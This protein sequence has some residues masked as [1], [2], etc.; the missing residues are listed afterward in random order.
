VRCV[1]FSPDAKRVA[2]GGGV[3]DRDDAPRDPVR[4]VEK[5]SGGEV[6]LWDA[7]TG[8][9]LRAV[10]AYRDYVTGIAFSPDGKRLAAGST[11][12]SVRVWDPE[13]GDELLALDGPHGEVNGIAYAPDGKQIAAAV[14]DPC[15]PDKPGEVVIWDAQTGKVER[16]LRGHER[17]VN[18]VAYSGDGR[19]LVSGGGCGGMG[20][21]G[22]YAGG[23]YGIA[24]AATPTY[25][26]YGGGP[27]SYGMHGCY[28]G[29]PGGVGEVKV[30]DPRTG[31][32]LLSLAGASSQVEK[33]VAETRTR[34]VAYTVLKTVQK[35]RNVVIDG[36]TVPQTYTEQVPTTEYRQVCEVIKKKVIVSAS[37]CVAS[38]AFSGDNQR[39]VCGDANGGVQVYEAHLC[40]PHANLRMYAG[41]L[42]CVAYS[43]DGRRL[44]TGGESGDTC[45]TCQ[46]GEVKVWDAITGEE[47]LSLRG[48]S[49]FIYGLAFSPDGTR[50]AVATGCVDQQKKPLPGEVKVWDLGEP[51]GVSP[52]REPLTLKGHAG[53]V[54]GVAWSPDGSRLVS[55]GTDRTVKLWS[56]ADGKVIQTIKGIPAEVNAVAYGPEGKWVAAA[57]GDRVNRDVPGEVRLFDAQTGDPIRTLKGLP[58]PAWCLALSADGKRIAAGSGVWDEKKREFTRGEVKVW[59]AATGNE[60]LTIQGHAAEVNG[61]GFGGDGKWVATAGGDWVVRV[62][63]AEN[64]NEVLALK[65]HAGVVTAVAC[66]PDGVHVASAGADSLVKVWDVVRARESVPHC[67]AA[68]PALGPASLRTEFD[69]WHLAFGPDG[70]RL[71]AGGIRYGGGVPT[72]VTPDEGGKPA[73]SRETGW[74][75][76]WDAARR[77]VIFTA[78][79]HDSPVIQVAWSPDGNL[80]ASA[81]GD[82]SIKLWDA[83]GKEQKALKHPGIRAVAFSPDG[84]KL[85]SGAYD[86]SVKFWD[87]QTGKEDKTVPRPGTGQSSHVAFSPDCKRVASIYQDGTL[88]VWDLEPAKELFVKKAHVSY[89]EAVAFS[90]DGAVVATASGVFD[91]EKGRWGRGQVKLWD[92]ATGR[93]VDSL[94]GHAGKV[95]GLSFSADGKWLA[96]TCAEEADVNNETVRVWD[97]KAGRPV[98][99]LSTGMF[100][101]RN[102][103]LSPDGS[104]LALP[105]YQAVKVW[106]VSALPAASPLAAEGPAEAQKPEDRA[107]AEWVLKKGGSVQVRADGAYLDVNGIDMLPQEPFRVAAIDLG[108]EPITDVDLENLKGL[109]DLKRLT[110]NDTPITGEGLG[111]LSASTR[112]EYLN[113]RHTKQLTDAALTHVGGMKG[114]TELHL[115]LTPITDAGLNHLKDLRNVRVLNLGATAVTDAGLEGLKDWARLVALL[116]EGT[117][118][119]GTGLAHL[120]ASKGLAVFYLQGCPITDEGLA[121]VAGFPK[122]SELYFDGKEVPLTDAGLAALEGMTDLQQLRLAGKITDAGLVHLKGLPRLHNLWLDN[123]PITDAG[124]EHLK[125]L[126]LGI[127]GLTNTKVTKEGEEKF[128]KALPKQPGP[129]PF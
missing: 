116:L 77:Q 57:V 129:P 50:L 73:P 31:L 102:I 54:T 62:W 5:V 27:G 39:I 59:D 124:L 44:A 78:K 89:P 99:Q 2:S 109:A 47:V 67:K 101:V 105:T 56:A 68:A 45:N 11:D 83:T 23:G 20:G 43:P 72:P 38:V 8:K 127:V 110:L 125:G 69:P 114:L 113:L 70:K 36:K 18:S 34:T 119:N 74:V 42:R 93:L 51:G 53:F 122:V 28:G 85:L 95:R 6:K 3:A 46:P 107:A 17:K 84:K 87:V 52:G 76:V 26:A 80:L 121:Q 96:T 22:F 88:R 30:W 117:K 92:A 97:R 81:A 75:T 65:D 7:E 24:P 103:A 64:G 66:S 115:N 37:S 9:E 1:A 90:P 14:G 100:N 86:G 13:T 15:V 60:A 4:M 49:G 41:V 19:R 106:D 118:V 104:R 25:G 10:K 40:Q 71:A 16:V 112:L 29:G 58:G 79:G 126:K 123:L 21:G 94:K 108:G 91:Q 32:E 61:V 33:E 48:H 120:K 128:R 63:D 55:G 82:G 111:H 12:E 35:T 98:A